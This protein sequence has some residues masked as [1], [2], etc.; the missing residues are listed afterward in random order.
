MRRLASDCA[1]YISK[2]LVKRGEDGS[3]EVSETVKAAGRTLLNYVS[4]RLT[5]RSMCTIRMLR[6][7]SCRLGGFGVTG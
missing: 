2:C 5:A 4:R 3:F 1:D 6:L 7:I